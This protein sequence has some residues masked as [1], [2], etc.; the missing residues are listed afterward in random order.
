MHSWFN[1][2]ACLIN[3]CSPEWVEIIQQRSITHLYPKGQY[4]FMEGSLVMGAYFILKGK[5]KVISSDQTG[6]EQTVRLA[7]EEHMLGHTAIGL[8]KYS[9]G[10]IT[11]ED[12]IICFIENNILYEAFMAN[13]KF[14]FEVMLFYS[15]EL[16]KSELRTKCLALM[17]NEEKVILGL[18]YIADTYNQEKTKNQV[19]IILSRQEIAQIIGTNADQVSR[20]LSSLKKDYLIETRERT[21]VIKN[22]NHLRSMLNKYPF[23]TG[24]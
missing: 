6:K 10:A 19:E 13:P 15:R 17:N 11:L 20:V 9:V 1:N 4:V 22:I 21:I 2:P 16:R 12:S 23:A 14:T 7:N 8:E 5:V 24:C 18:L 3:Y